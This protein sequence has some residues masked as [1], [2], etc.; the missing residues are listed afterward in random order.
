MVARSNNQTNT[1]AIVAGGVVVAGLLLYFFIPRSGPVN[2]ATGGK[3]GDGDKSS[4]AVKP[5]P[6]YSPAVKRLMA[7]GLDNVTLSQPVPNRLPKSNELGAGRTGWSLDVSYVLKGKP[8]NTTFRAIYLFLDNR[9]GTYAIPSKS[10]A[11]PAAANRSGE[12]A[13]T[14]LL[15]EAK[16]KFRVLLPVEVM[17]L[18]QGDKLKVMLQ[19]VV[20]ENQFIPASNELNLPPLP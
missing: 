2:P 7:L 8:D 12:G 15:K 18:K 19:A 13:N 4:S 11:R 5:L 20:G 16:G 10:S 9:G 6:T 17:K 3:V 14:F 1:P